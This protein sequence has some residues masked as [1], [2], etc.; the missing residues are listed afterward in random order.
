MTATQMEELLG[1]KF[2]L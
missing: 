1:M 2:K